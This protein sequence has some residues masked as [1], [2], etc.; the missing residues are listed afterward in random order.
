MNRFIDLM[1][2]KMAKLTHLGQHS[3]YQLNEGCYVI[4]LCRWVFYEFSM[5]KYKGVSEVFDKN[6]KSKNSIYKIY[7]R[8]VMRC[9]ALPICKLQYCV[10][11]RK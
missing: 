9:G 11:L 5:F 8:Y 6:F 10:A 7:H 1:L 2:L 4:V 3:L